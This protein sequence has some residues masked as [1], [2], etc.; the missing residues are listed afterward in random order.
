MLCYG[1]GAGVVE[2]DVSKNRSSSADEG[3]LNEEEDEAKQSS[4]PLCL[5]CEDSPITGTGRIL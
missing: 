3:V 4:G 2:G 5:P 1:G